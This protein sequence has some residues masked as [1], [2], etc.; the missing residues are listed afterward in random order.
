MRPL[1]K[2][3]DAIAHGLAKELG[4]KSY[5]NGHSRGN[6][7]Y[8]WKWYKYGYHTRYKQHAHIAITNGTIYIYPI[9]TP[10]NQQESP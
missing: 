10:T 5:P 8:L 3:H 7:W 6:D 2:T 9:I 4:A 1:R